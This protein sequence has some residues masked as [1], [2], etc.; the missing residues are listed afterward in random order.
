MLDNN[1]LGFT[2]D[3]LNFNEIPD[4][5]KSYLTVNPEWD[6]NLEDYIL[7]DEKDR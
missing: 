5:I 4:F 7:G 3:D 6:D 2:I 1:K